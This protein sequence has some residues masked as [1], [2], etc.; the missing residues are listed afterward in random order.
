MMF[1]FTSCHRM[2]R[3]TSTASLPALEK[4][5]YS[6]M[7]APNPSIPP[8]AL[9]VPAPLAATISHSTSGSSVLAAAAS[10]AIAATQQVNNR[11]PLTNGSSVCTLKLLDA[12]RTP[13]RQH[14]SIVRSSSTVCPINW[15]RRA[16]PDSE[17]DISTKWRTRA[18]ANTYKLNDSVNEETEKVCP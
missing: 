4:S 2:N 5:W 18:C 10:Q 12:T 13:E 15:R 17:L 1:Q 14:E 9:P 3:Q 7:P 16:Q 6:E 11:K 8:S